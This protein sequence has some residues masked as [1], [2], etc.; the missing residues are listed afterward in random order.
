MLCLQNYTELARQLNSKAFRDVNQR[1]EQ[2][3][4]GVMALYN[5]KLLH[6]SNSILHVQF[7][8]SDS[9]N[10]A[11][12]N[13]VCAALLLFKMN[14]LPTAFPLQLSALLF[15]GDTNNSLL[16]RLSYHL[17]EQT[18]FQQILVR[19]PEN[20]LLIQAQLLE[21]AALTQRLNPADYA[22]ADDFARI[23]TVDQPYQDLLDKQFQQLTKR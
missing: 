14:Q 6:A 12:F 11:I 3:L 1:L 8:S 7:T 15:A 4:V 13:G 17:A 5:G 19:A 16:K 21:D 23:D 10:D 20:S 2:H 9:E 22:D 18:D